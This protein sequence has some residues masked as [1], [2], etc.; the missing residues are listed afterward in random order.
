MFSQEDKKNLNWC[1][2]STVLQPTIGLGDAWE[3][4]ERPPEQMMINN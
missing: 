4:K 2:L 3:I 1:R